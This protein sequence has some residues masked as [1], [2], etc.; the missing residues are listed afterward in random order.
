MIRIPEDIKKY[1]K[2][3]IEETP[4]IVENFEKNEKEALEFLT[5]KVLQKTKKDKKHE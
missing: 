1:C 5:S 3:V 2:E 4:Q